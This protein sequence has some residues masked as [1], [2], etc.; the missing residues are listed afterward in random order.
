MSYFYITRFSVPT[1]TRT[2]GRTPPHP[3]P[4]SCIRIEIANITTGDTFLYSPPPPLIEYS[5]RVGE[6]IAPFAPPP[7]PWIRHC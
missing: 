3:F 2:P 6:G 4:K 5:C 1:V 7:P